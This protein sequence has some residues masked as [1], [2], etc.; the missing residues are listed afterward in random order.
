MKTNI[1]I[2]KVLL[3]GIA[4]AFLGMGCAFS[5]KLPSVTVGG[6][7]NKDAVLDMSAGKQGVSVTAPLVHVNVPFPSVSAKDDKKK[8]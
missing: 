5:Q 8:K 3:M 1:N 4:A 2:K 7:A 6:A